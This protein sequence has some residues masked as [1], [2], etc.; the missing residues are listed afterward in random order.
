MSKGSASANLPL[1]RVRTIMKSSPEVETVSQ[2]SLYLITRAT[3][4]FIMYLSK[5]GQRN[6]EDHDSVTYSDL[7][8]VV[9]RKDS[10]D[11]L[12]D[13]VPKK[14]KFSDYLKIMEEEKSDD[15]G[16]F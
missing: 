8:A 2:E 16:L 1:A 14:I 6:G 13:I 11:F 4:L 3:E 10:M 12:Q 7:A 5:L 9:Q 15:D